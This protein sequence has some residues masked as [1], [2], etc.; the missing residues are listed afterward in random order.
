MEA[1]MEPT[2]FEA[3]K[4]LR[5]DIPA[6]A[7]LLSLGN[8]QE[9]DSWANIIDAKLLSRFSP[10]FPLVAAICGGGSSGKSTLFNSLLGEKLAPTGGRAGMN[11]RLL[12]SIPAEYLDQPGFLSD[13]VEPYKTLP[14]PLQDRH[15]LLAPGN[16]L[17]VRHRSD[18]KNLVLLDTPDFDT[19]AQGSYTNRGVTQKA[20]EASDILIYIFTNSNY[21][22]RDNT[23][24]ISRMLTGIG[25]RKCFLVYRVYPSFT[26]EEVREHAMV[27]ARGIYGDDAQNYLL[28]I[29]RADEDNRV[30][31]GEQFMALRAVA[32]GNTSLGDEL[33]AIDAR[34]LRWELH[35]SIL[36]DVLERSAGLLADAG[37][38]LDELHLYLDALQTAQGQCVHEAL[39]HFPM[40]S[41]MRRFAKIWS[42]TD[43]AHIKVMRKTGTLIEFPLKAILGT[44]GWAKRRLYSEKSKESSA[45]DFQEKL[46]EDLITAVT[47]L[48]Q[49]AVSPQLS[50]KNSLSDPVARRM[51]ETIE[52][53]RL[54]KSLKKAQNPQADLSGEGSLYTF[55]VDAHPAVLSEQEKLRNKDF[56]PILQSI[57]AH[58]DIITAISQEM[59]L[60]LKNLADHFRSKMSLWTKVSQTFWALMNVVPA[61]VAVTYVLS[62]GDAAG[63]V[64]IK[65][66]L[67]GLFGAKD[68]YALFAIPATTGLK[69]ADQK[70]LE[71]ML[72]PIVQ[73]WLNHKLKKVQALFERQITGGLI[74]GAG[75]S[76][77]ETDRLIKEIEN[78]MEE[79]R[80]E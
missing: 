59:E 35:A 32:S 80:R 9:I 5:S 62:T 60:D 3:L 10:D 26:E 74:R 20:L 67:A 78:C 53:V 45:K 68:L 4:C 54:R 24:F 15:D 18:L 51:L 13:L 31:A 28:G 25:R 22:N 27:V 23:D 58:K 66:K 49:Q 79:V 17:Y 2:I 38:S 34:R 50:L 44:A 40:D 36:N 72:G 69:K 64:G 30:A 41:V 46:D 48:Y 56:K 16:P 75:E 8:Q 71:A 21:R 6:L 14:E 61:T 52:G 73:T 77:A 37:T 39:K 70:Q 1:Q 11:R 57:L 43:P 55:G 47:E 29:Y 63:A 42:E 76:I 65:V 12:F 7:G 33:A 19:G